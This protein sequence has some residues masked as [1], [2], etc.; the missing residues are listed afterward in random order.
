MY[1]WLPLASVDFL[2]SEKCCDV[3]KKAPAHDFQKATGK[4]P[5]LATMA[6]ESKMRQ[7]SWLHNGC[8]AFD[9]K[10]PHSAPMSFWTE[11]DILQYIKENS[12]P[13]ASVYGDIVTTG[14]A[15]ATASY[16]LLDMQD[17]FND[18]KKT[19]EFAK[20]CKQGA[21]EK[22]CTTGCDRTGCVFCG[23]GAHIGKGESRFEKL[24]RTH[25]RQYEYCLG[26]GAYDTDGLWKT[27]KDGL[28]MQHIFNVLNNIY[29]KDFIKY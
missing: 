9:I 4:V 14:T 29:G 2:I 25:P 16:S 18:E 22:L 1:K 27:T 24:K 26:G 12:L 5:I 23:F 13:I 21:C 28:G 19:I 7:D 20:K 15:Q 6:H 8:N 11:Q 17:I 3:M 10:N